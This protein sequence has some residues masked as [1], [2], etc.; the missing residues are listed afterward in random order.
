MKALDK[1]LQNWVLENLDMDLIF[2]EGPEFTQDTLE[3]LIIYSFSEETEY[4]DLFRDICTEIV[5]EVGQFDNFILNLFHEIGHY[6]SEDYFDDNE[7][8]EYIDFVEGLGS[9]PTKEDYIKY[10][11]HPIEYSATE[12]GMYTIK[13]HLNTVRELEEYIKQY[14]DI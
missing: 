13:Y 12:E 6:L 1:Y 5:P 2:E 14:K 7:W 10:Y 9:M 3:D 4:D 8:E 11:K